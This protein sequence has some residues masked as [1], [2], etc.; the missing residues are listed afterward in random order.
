MEKDTAFRLVNSETP[1]KISYTTVENSGHQIVFDNA[2][3]MVAYL[4]K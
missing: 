1:N 4:I 2:P 3:L